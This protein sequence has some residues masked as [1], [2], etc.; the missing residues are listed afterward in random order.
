MAFIDRLD[1]ELARVFATMPLEDYR[2][3]TDLPATR[4]IAARMFAARTAG[5]TDSPHVAKED[6][7]VP[8]P[9]GAPAV[10]IRIYRP[11]GA[12][13]PLPCLFWIH[14]GGFVLGSLAMDDFVMQ[15]YVETIGCVAVSVEY[16]LAP[17][18]PFPSA[19]DDCYAALTWTFAHAAAL[20]IDP[21]RIA[22]GGASA[23]GGLAAGLVL[24]AR[25]R[26]EIAISFQMLIYP[27]LDDRSTTPRA[28]RSPTHGSGTARQTTTAGA[29]TWAPI[30]GVRRSRLMRP[31]RAPTTC[32]TCLRPISWWEH[33][34][35]SWT[36]T[37]PTRSD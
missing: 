8:G 14:G 21:E 17:E 15:H 32:T 26:A 18:H 27:M 36:R 28:T 7:A 34:T 11:A 31:R 10:P 20:G 23:G 3:W 2:D 25:D 35:S 16:R 37:S 33:R 13:G 4:A 1:P 5:M 22:V 30:R 9:D 6:H 24:L 12:S 19:I 29:P